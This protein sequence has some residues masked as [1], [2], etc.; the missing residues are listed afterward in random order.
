MPPDGEYLIVAFDK[1]FRWDSN[2]LSGVRERRV[3]ALE[4]LAPWAERIQAKQG[5][6]MTVNLKVRR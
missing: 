4:R 6:S 1:Y 5:T 2:L 3:A